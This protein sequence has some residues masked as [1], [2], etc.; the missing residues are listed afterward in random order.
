MG[1]ILFKNWL[2]LVKGVG[3]VTNARK[4]NNFIL[5]IFGVMKGLISPKIFGKWKRI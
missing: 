3:A 1:Y 2:E 5:L 4:Y